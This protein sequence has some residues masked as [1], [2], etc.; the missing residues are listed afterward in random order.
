[1]RANKAA[2]QLLLNKDIIGIFAAI[3]LNFTPNL[4]QTKIIKGENSKV[5]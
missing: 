2:V 4:K 1:M 3:F 5:K